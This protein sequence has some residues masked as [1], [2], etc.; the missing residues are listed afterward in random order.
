MA[1]LQDRT[2]LLSPPFIS[3]SPRGDCS[4][5]WGSGLCSSGQGRGRVSTAE[6][7]GQAST[8]PA[9]AHFLAEAISPWILLE[10]WGASVRQQKGSG[11]APAPESWRAGRRAAA[12]AAGPLTHRGVRTRPARPRCHRP[13]GARAETRA[14]S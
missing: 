12:A 7:R 6:S 1:V 8:R 4:K 10:A 2:A 13:A 5:S 9:S 14:P 11:P 3:R